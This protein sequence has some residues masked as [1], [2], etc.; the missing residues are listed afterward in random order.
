[1]SRIIKAENK[2]KKYRLYFSSPFNCILCWE[3]PRS[4]HIL[5]AT[6]A[7]HITDLYFLILCVDRYSSLADS[8]HEVFFCLLVLRV[9]EYKLWIS[10]LCSLLKSP[11]L[12]S[13]FAPRYSP[14]HPIVRHPS[15]GVRN[16]SSRA[17]EHA[18]N[19]CFAGETRFPKIPSNTGTNLFPCRSKDPRID[20]QYN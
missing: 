14:Q 7:A 15:V 20:S 3:G 10:S 13:L 8:G 4:T 16:Y 1:M 17:K 11:V 9:V 12:S 18:S 19:L 5:S 2:C 6:C